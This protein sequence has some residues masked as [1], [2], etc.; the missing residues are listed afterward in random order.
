MKLVICFANTKRR[1]TSTR[2]RCNRDHDKPRARLGLLALGCKCDE[3][4]CPVHSP[5]QE[6][7]SASDGAVSSDVGPI[8]T[9]IRLVGIHSYQ[10]HESTYTI[11]MFSDSLWEVVRHDRSR[12]RLQSKLDSGQMQGRLSSSCI[13]LLAQSAVVRSHQHHGHRSMPHARKC[14]L[15]KPEQP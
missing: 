9:R 15:G 13:H 12:V 7:S 2:T 1:L 11:M 8:Y 5:S 6:R 4:T 3:S 14:G 10:Q